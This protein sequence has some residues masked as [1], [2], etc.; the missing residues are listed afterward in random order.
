[1]RKLLG[2]LIR[3]ALT[4]PDPAVLINWGV[5]T[6]QNRFKAVGGT[7]TGAKDGDDREIVLGDPYAHAREINVDI[8]IS[9]QRAEELFLRGAQGG[10]GRRVIVNRRG[11]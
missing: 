5:N 3:W 2:R 9:A 10:G 11:V 8:E 7:I 1:M 4:S 6:G